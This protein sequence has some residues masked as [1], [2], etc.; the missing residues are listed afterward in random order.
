M[1]FAN[2]K[3]ADAVPIIIVISA[4]LLNI[5]IGV[6]NAIGFSALMIRCIVVTIIFGLFGYM[7]TETIKKAIECSGINKMTHDDDEVTA[8]VEE[9]HS[10]N[11]I[12]SI[13]DIKVP[14]LD[15][16]EFMSMDNYND[17]EFVEVNPAYMGKNNEGEQ[18]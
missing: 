14:P 10:D 8:D 4:L 3:M 5:A 7:V 16:E 6:I 11:E 13:L 17:D 2:M 1:E 12:D 15:D 9:N 18:E